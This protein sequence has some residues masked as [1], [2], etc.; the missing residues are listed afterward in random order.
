MFFQIPGYIRPVNQMWVVGDN[1]LNVTVPQFMNWRNYKGKHYYLNR[2]YEVTPYTVMESNN[3]LVQIQKGLVRAIN[4]NNFLPEIILVLMSN[5]IPGNKI[6]ALK[7]EF[8]IKQIMQIIR[9]SIIRREDQLPTKAKSIFKTKILFTKALPKPEDQDFK[10][11][12]RKYNKQLNIIGKQYN[13][14][15]IHINDI[16]PSDKSMFL[17]PDLSEVG[18]RKMWSIISDKIKNLDQSDAEALDRRRTERRTGQIDTPRDTWA[19]S[20]N[21]QRR[22]EPMNYLG[23]AIEQPGQGRNHHHANR[24][25]QQNSNN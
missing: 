12:R 15:T 5:I 10:I 14:E 11:Q 7:Q 1:L 2:C 25:F 9:E 13:I 20:S 18:K 24:S 4:A 19:R 6:L 3:F 21:R 8:Y 22:F 17:G 16:L 23:I